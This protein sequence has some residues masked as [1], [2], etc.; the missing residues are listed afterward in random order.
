MLLTFVVCATANDG[1]KCFSLVDE[2]GQRITKDEARNIRKRYPGKT[3][4]EIPAD[5]K[6]QV[7]E[8]VN[9]QLGRQGVPTVREDVLRWRML[10]IMREMKRQHLESLSHPT[11]PGS[12]QD[13]R[14]HW[15]IVM[16]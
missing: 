10:Q 3:W 15:N 14:T 1:V 6:M 4:P 9:E 8:K 16:Q 2:G 5:E 7:L 12:P 11:S 13:G